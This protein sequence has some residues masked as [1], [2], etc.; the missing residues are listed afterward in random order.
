M[1]KGEN[2]K[3]D[4]GM[5]GLPKGYL[6]GSIGESFGRSTTEEVD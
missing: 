3:I 6:W 1:T 2:Q 4:W 5:I